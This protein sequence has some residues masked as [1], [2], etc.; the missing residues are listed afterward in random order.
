MAKTTFIDALHCV[1]IEFFEWITKYPFT[2]RVHYQN[3]TQEIANIAN[4]FWSRASRQTTNQNRKQFYFC[5]EIL[6]FLFLKCQ[7]C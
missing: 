3:T 7:I 6:D 4:R 1:R 5:F 2:F